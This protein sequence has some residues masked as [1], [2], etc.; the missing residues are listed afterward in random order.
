MTLQ[1]PPTRRLIAGVRILNTRCAGYTVVHKS[2]QETGTSEYGCSLT[3]CDNVL[4]AA[5]A[6]RV[7]LLHCLLNLKCI[8][9]RHDMLDPV[10]RG[11]RRWPEFPLVAK[12]GSP[13]MTS[14]DMS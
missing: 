7:S 9:I 10:I 11:R 14:R 4:G 8:A 3:L 2:A 13:L 6:L 1:V 5:P 12:R